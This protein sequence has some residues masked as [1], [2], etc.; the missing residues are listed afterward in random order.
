MR[1]HVRLLGYRHMFAPVRPTTKHL[2]P[3]TPMAAF[4][5]RRDE[6]GLPA[7]PWLRVHARA[8]GEIVK[9]APASM[10]I[11]ASVNQWSR[12][13]GMSFPSSGDMIVPGALVPVHVSLEQD[14]VVYVEPNVWIRHVI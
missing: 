11:S 7:D 14:H 2:E 1:Q 10:V 9:I 5:A 13:T 4:V 3:L 12:W 6:D 8:G